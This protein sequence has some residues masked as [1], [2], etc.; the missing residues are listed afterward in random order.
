MACTLSFPASIPTQ[1]TVAAKA[2]GR[3]CRILLEF[4]G[5]RRGE[6]A[7]VHSEISALQDGSHYVTQAGFKLE[8]SASAS[9]VGLWHY[10]TNKL[11]IRPSLDCVD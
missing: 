11:L 9:P 3:P 2:A 5:E 10:P 4:P 1:I 6:E 7:G 8:S